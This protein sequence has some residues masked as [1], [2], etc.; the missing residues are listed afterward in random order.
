MG[1]EYNN[2]YFTSLFRKKTKRYFTGTIPLLEIRKYQK[3]TYLLLK[4]LPFY[5]LIKKLTQKYT[6]RK[7][8]WSSSSL[9]IL[10]EALEYYL[11]YMLIDCKTCAL[12]CNR[13]TIMP[14]DMNLVKRIMEKL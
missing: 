8:K 12:H 4:K 1:M 10:Q 14:K 5:K 3:T 7:L 9:F 6:K 13:V 11:N 2:D